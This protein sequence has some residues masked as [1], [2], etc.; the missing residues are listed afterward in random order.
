MRGSILAL[1]WLVAAGPL[2][3][4]PALAGPYDGLYRPDEDWAAG[5]DCRT[6]GMDG[7]A[8]GVSGDAF[9]GVE[10]LCRLTNPVAVRGMSATLYDADC[11]GEGETWNSRMMLMATRDG[12]IVIEDGH[13]SRLKRCE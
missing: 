6:V 7:G 13:A 2:L 5:W 9:R 12:L 4:G 3:A 10:S 8:I 1:A 11:A